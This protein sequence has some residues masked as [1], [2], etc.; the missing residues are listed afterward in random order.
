MNDRFFRSNP[1]PL[2][3]LPEG[4]QN[5]GHTRSSALTDGSF[6]KLVRTGKTPYQVPQFTFQPLDSLYPNY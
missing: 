2:F 1:I 6:D 5:V 4:R 3:P